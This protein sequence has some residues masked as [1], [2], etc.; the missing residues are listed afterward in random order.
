MEQQRY[1]FNKEPG[2]KGTAQRAAIFHPFYLVHIWPGGVKAHHVLV[3]S[4]SQESAVTL[5]TQV[6]A[7][8]DP[9]FSTPP[10]YTVR[11][12]IT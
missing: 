1:G 12:N 2:T 4:G 7:A 3:V 9:R 5:C 8:K 6:R 11:P 10:F